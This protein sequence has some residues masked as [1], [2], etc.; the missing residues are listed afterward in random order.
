[1]VTVATDEDLALS[2]EDDREFCQGEEVVIGLPSEVFGSLKS[3]GSFY[4]EGVDEP[5]VL[6]TGQDATVTSAGML[7]VEAFSEPPCVVRSE[8][9]IHITY[10]DCDLVIPNVIT[11]ATTT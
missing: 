1:M 10:A 9:I 5:V 4:E 8:G 7:V 6:A 3:T 2:W 11:L